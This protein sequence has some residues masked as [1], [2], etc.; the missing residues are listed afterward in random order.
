MSDTSD[1]EKKHATANA[2]DTMPPSAGTVIDKAE[3]DEALEI[4]NEVEHDG[5]VLIDIDDKK[6]RWKIDLHIMPIM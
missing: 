6:L 2:S 1:L 4:F 5:E 3:V